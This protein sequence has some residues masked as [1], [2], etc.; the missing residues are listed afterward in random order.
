MHKEVGLGAL[1]TVWFRLM[2]LVIPGLALAE[3]LRLSRGIAQDWYYVVFGLTGMALGTAAIQVAPFLW[4]FKVAR[5]R[6]PAWTVR[7][8]MF[9]VPIFEIRKSS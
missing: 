9:V 7:L 6:L 2:N 8:G 5:E 3:T 4:Y 1:S